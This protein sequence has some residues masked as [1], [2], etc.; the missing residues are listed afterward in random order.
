M[1]N[2]KLLQPWFKLDLKESDNKRNETRAR[3][4]Q[5]GEAAAELLPD[6]SHATAN[7]S[8]LAHLQKL[9]TATLS[10]RTMNEHFYRRL[11]KFTVTSS[12]SHV[13]RSLLSSHTCQF[14]S[15]ALIHLQISGP[16]CHINCPQ[17]VMT[18]ADQDLFDTMVNH[19]II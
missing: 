11:F 14:E 19:L 7:V 12:P 16:T 4:K 8:L 5:G 15:V 3:A 2:P 10:E 1:N 18:G 17:L 13:G 6:K 9:S